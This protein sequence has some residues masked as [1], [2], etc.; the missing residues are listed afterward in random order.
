MPLV[1]PHSS[2]H[3]RMD[4]SSSLIKLLSVKSSLGMCAYAVK[5]SAF[6]PLSP[7]LAMNIA[8]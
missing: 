6:S 2:H 1:N 5:P 7:L 4:L 3:L 8:L